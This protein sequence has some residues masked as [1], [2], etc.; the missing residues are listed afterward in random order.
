MATVLNSLRARAVHGFHLL[1]LPRPVRRFYWRAWRLRAR[2]GDAFSLGGATKPRELRPLLAAAEGAQRVVEIGTGTAWTTIAL[3]LADGT[4]TVTSI[5]PVRRPERDA[6]LELVPAS[7]A[8]RIA[9]VEGVGEAAPP[10]G[11]DGVGFLFIDA[12]H[13]QASTEGAFRAW[14]DRLAPGAGVAFHDFD[15]PQWPGVTEAIRSLGLQ[16]AASHHL[17]VWRAPQ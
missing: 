13:D 3:A 7:V 5:D 12:N 17:F 4:R 11:I 6:Y 14:R 8:K 15:D 1:A 2:L 9:F 10:A 16:G